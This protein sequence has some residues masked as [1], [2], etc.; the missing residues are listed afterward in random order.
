MAK[1]GVGGKGEGINPTYQVTRRIRSE[2]F[3]V[4]SKGD[5]HRRS[6]GFFLLRI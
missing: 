6:S 5:A 1:G 2:A 4:S 3:C